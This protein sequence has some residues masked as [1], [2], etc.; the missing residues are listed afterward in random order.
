MRNDL[1]DELVNNF[2]GLHHEL[3]AGWLGEVGD[4][5]FDGVAADDGLALGAALQKLVHLQRK[6][7]KTTMGNSSRG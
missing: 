3:N 4:H 5:L 2:S 7:R 6:R 1:L